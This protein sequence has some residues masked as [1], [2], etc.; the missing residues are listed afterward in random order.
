MANN[1][2]SAT[3]FWTS[4]DKFWARHH[5]RARHE[6]SMPSGEQGP[7]RVQELLPCRMTQLDH[8]PNDSDDECFDLWTE[9]ID[10]Q[11]PGE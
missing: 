10:F 2:S 3:D 1:P 6:L 8:S 4:G 5:V 7:P 11:H 9:D